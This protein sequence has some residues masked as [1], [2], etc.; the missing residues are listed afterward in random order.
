MRTTTRFALA[1]AAGLIGAPGTGCAPAA[2]ANLSPTPEQAPDR[3]ENATRYSQ[4][5]AQKNQEGERKVM[6]RMTR[7]HPQR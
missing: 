6:S 7:S 3:H 1:L 2:P 4:E 5:L